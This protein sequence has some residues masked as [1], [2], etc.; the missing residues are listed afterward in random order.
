MA[1]AAITTQDLPTRQPKGDIVPAILLILWALSLAI[2]QIGRI[3]VLGQAGGILVS[4]AANILIVI[5]A[6]V[7]A[8]REISTARRVRWTI[9]AITPF[10]FW[11][12]FTLLLHAQSFSSAEALVAASYWIR[13]AVIVALLPAFIILFQQKGLGQRTFLFLAVILPLLGYIQ[14][15]VQPSLE[16]ISG[17]WDPHRFRM[18]ATWLD[19]N[20]FGAFLALMLPY[21]LR[22]SKTLGVWILIA[23]ILT[24]SRSTFL[25]IA[26]AGIVGTVLLLLSAR[27]SP[28]AKQHA[29]ALVTGVLLCVMFAGMLLGDRA[30]NVL[31]HD[32]TTAIRL[33]GYAAV[34]RQLVEPNMLLG[35]GY[36]AY[37]FAA[38]DAGLI[39]DF[40]LHSR[41]GADSSILTLLVTTGAIGTAL[42]LAPILGGAAIHV[43]R[44]LHT[45][46]TLSLC[47][48]CATAVLLVHSQFT[49]SL[50][51]PHLLMTYLFLA[52]LSYE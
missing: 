4:D 44:F 18:V 21:A 48:I 10:L 22:R 50:L 25:A 32:P 45:K 34:W 35:V 14:L 23:I 52:A 33:E 24:Q 30:A 47:F 28:R 15:I 3:P 27:L 20:F 36:N 6:A 17:G 39:S 1:P 5:Y 38:K 40:S 29:M 41:A 2:G 12:L 8:L 13:L 42:F 11:A 46:N 9:V 49:N 31:L 19:P 7:Y 37:Q 51:Y 43:R 16:G 26:V